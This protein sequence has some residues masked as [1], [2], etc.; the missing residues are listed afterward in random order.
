MR[1]AFLELSPKHDGLVLW[2]VFG[3]RLREELTS[4]MMGT[5]KKPVREQT[6]PPLIFSS[7]FFATDFLPEKG[8]GR[9]ASGRGPLA[10][11]HL[12][13]LGRVLSQVGGRT[14]GQK[15]SPI[16]PKK[17]ETSLIGKRNIGKTKMARQQKFGPQVKIVYFRLEMGIFQTARFVSQRVFEN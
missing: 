14:E 16:D 15:G 12:R 17:F 2:S 3:G 1:A 8:G 6:P 7:R 4:A 9:F 5:K 10:S 13:P 11:Q